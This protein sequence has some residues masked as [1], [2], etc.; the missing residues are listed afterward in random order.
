MVTPYST[1]NTPGVLTWPDTANMRVPLDA[2]APS[3]VKALAP[4]EMIHGRFESVSTLL[5]I[6]GWRYRPLAAG[7]N[8]GLSRGMPRLP[9]RLSMRPVSSPTM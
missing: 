9:S 3:A 2:S 4:L 7:K 1:S 6:V 5:T 8:G